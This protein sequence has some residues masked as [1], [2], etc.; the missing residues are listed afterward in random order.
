[1]ASILSSQGVVLATAM[2][3]SGTVILLA[4]RLQKSLPTSAH[5]QFPVVGQIDP[6]AAQSS[7]QAAALRSCISATADGKKR[8]EKK[9]KKKKRVHFA[10]DVVDPIGYS[11]EFRRQHGIIITNRTYNNN[12]HSTDYCY[13]PSPS[14]SSSSSTSSPK[15]IKK[16]G[17]KVVPE[18]PANRIALYNGI[19]RDRVVH[20]LACSY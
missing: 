17:G 10:E 15:F 3:V 18:M 7:R 4:L 13:N 19:L 5:H 8:S 20:R 11:E 9:K 14:T 1:M 12:Y 16:V 2:A 6:A